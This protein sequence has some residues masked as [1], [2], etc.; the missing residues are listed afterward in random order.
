MARCK[1]E[2]GAVLK[3]SLTGFVGPVMARTD[4]FTGCVHYGLQ[5]SKLDKDGKPEFQYVWFDESRMVDTGK[6]LKLPGKVTAARSGP[7]P[8]APSVS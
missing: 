8:N 2:I 6:T 1:F 4:Y 3:D 7:H 5:V